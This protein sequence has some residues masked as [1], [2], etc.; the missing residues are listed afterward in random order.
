VFG[1]ATPENT[2]Y[3]FVETLRQ[4]ALNTAINDPVISA[5]WIDPNTRNQ[6]AEVFF[7]KAAVNFRV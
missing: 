5:D 1:G 4:I 2:G 3:V 7:V 6:L